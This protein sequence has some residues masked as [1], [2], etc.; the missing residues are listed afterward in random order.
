MYERLPHEAFA[1]LRELM[2]DPEYRLYWADDYDRH[3]NQDYIV[4]FNVADGEV[5][6]V[7]PVAYYQPEYD[8]FWRLVRWN[9]RR[10]DLGKH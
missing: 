8:A 10:L 6:W 7:V 1:E 5:R 4:V 3:E 9:N 2:E